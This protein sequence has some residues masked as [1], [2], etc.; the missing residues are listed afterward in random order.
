GTWNAYRYNS[1]IFD[2]YYNFFV[3]IE[4]RDT[5]YADSGFSSIIGQTGFL[6]MLFYVLFKIFLF[7]SMYKRFQHNTF[8]LR[9]ISCWIIFNMVSFFVSD[10]MISNF[11]ITSSFFIAILYL[12]NQKEENDEEP[13]KEEIGCEKELN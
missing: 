7:L 2:I 9:V 11:F 10:S 1:P 13:I 4:D 6:G 8:L 5:V 3:W 12:Q